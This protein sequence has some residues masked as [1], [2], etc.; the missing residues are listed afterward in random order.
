MITLMDHQVS[1]VEFFEK[2]GRALLYHAT[3]TGK[4]F[5]I[6]ECARRVWEKHGSQSPVL[7]LCPASVVKQWHEEARKYLG[8]NCFDDYALLVTNYEKLLNKELSAKL[9]STKWMLIAADECQKI[10]NPGA[11]ST[12]AFKK[13]STTY[14]IA[15][16]ATPSSNSALHELWSVVDWLYPSL[17]EAS[18][19]KFKQYQCLTNYFGGITGYKDEESIRTKIAPL[20]HRI[21]K[22][23]LTDLPPL[24]ER[25]ITVHLNEHHREVYEKMKKECQIEIAGKKILIPN[26]VAMIN[27]MRQMTDT[28]S[29]LGVEI[30]SPKMKALHVLLESKTPTI[31]FVEYQASAAEIGEAFNCPII[32]GQTTMAARHKIIS[33][34]QEGEHD[35]IVGTYAMAVGINAQHCQRVISYSQYWNPSRMDQAVGRSW[36]KGQTNT[37]EHITLIAERTVDEKIARLIDKK[38]NAESKFSR[39]EILS[40]L[41]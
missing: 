24:V 8:I 16:S 36:R 11:R 15:A 26:A 34:F 41:Q 32:T 9:V 12:K 33:E 40:L 29:S 18:F 37:V 31:V 10:S 7:I 17:L 6:L 5:T 1:A 3:G 21:E 25:V 23:V 27:K 2:S 30:A 28:P 22:S 38:R 20:I 13:L 4:S 14:K 39:E 35:V 19:W